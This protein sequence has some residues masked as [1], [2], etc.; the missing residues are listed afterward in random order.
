MTNLSQ[1]RMT[2]VHKIVQMS[3]GIFAVL[4]MSILN[5]RL[6]LKKVFYF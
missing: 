5:R 4:L 2:A 1:M 3:A 6:L